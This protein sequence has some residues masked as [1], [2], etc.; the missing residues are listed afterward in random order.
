MIL[1]KFLIF[2]VFEPCDSY[3][4]DS[5]KKN[6]VTLVMLYIGNLRLKLIKDK[7]VLEIGPLLLFDVKIIDYY[8]KAIAQHS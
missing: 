1:R 5:Y 4:E 3:K 6:S 8:L 7:K 2:S